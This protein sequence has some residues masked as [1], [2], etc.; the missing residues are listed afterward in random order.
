M[1]ETLSDLQIDAPLYTYQNNKIKPGDL[2]EVKLLRKTSG[3]AKK[4]YFPAPVLPVDLSTDVKAYTEVNACRPTHALQTGLFSYVAWVVLVSEQ[5]VYHL[6][7][8]LSLTG[9]VAPCCLTDRLC[10]RPSR[11]STGAVARDWAAAHVEQHARGR[12]RGALPGAGGA[13]HRV[14]EAADQR[15]AQGDRGVLRGPLITWFRV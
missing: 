9:Q 5:Q 15:E 6:N 11:M 4:A 7:R 12:L 1:H 13:V 3:T 14:H 2:V 8:C 10:A